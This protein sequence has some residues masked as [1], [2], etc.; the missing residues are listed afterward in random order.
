MNSN[1]VSKILIIS[2]LFLLAAC[3]GK[4]GDKNVGQVVAKVNDEE[5]SIHQVNYML[6]RSNGINQENLESAKKQIVNSLIDQAM[7]NQQSLAAKLDRDPQIMMAIEQ[8]KRQILAQAWLERMVAKVNKPSSQEVDQYYDDHPD[9]FAK[10]KSFKLK[11][12]SINKIEVDQEKLNMILAVNKQIEDLIKK[13]DAEKIP[14]KVNETTQE[15][16][17]L[18]LDQLPA[19]TK[20]REGEFVVINNGNNVLLISVHGKVEQ[21]V[22]KA[23][24]KPIIETFLINQQRKLLVEKEMKD[25]KEKA[26]IEYIGE[27]SELKNKAE[28]LP[29]KLEK[30]PKITNSDVKDDVITKGLKGM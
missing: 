20:L 23:K 1:R 27:F 7:L 15:A 4:E 29:N 13:L 9:L 24:A 16:E 10:H 2:S 18:P 26:K 6:S 5:I 3:G 11:E 30:D 19:L 28:K 17:N 22:D 8:N 25:L 12:V 21:A 14:Y